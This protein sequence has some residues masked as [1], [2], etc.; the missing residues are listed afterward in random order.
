MEKELTVQ[1]MPSA[2]LHVLDNILQEYKAKVIQIFLQLDPP[3]IRLLVEN[4]ECIND[5]IQELSLS[6]HVFAVSPSLKVTDEYNEG[7]VT[8]DPYISVQRALADIKAFDAWQI[9]KGSRDVA[10]AVIDKGVQWKNPDLLPN[11]IPTRYTTVIHDWEYRGG[12]PS[13]WWVYDGITDDSYIHVDLWAG[14]VQHGTQM[15]GII[16]AQDN[17]ATGTTGVAPDCYIASPSYHGSMDYFAS[18]MILI[19]DNPQLN[20]KVFAISFGYNQNYY[21]QNISNPV[22]NFVIS[23]I[24]YA[25]DRGILCVFA[26]G[27]YGTVQP[28]DHKVAFP[29]C[30]TR[31][32]SDGK[33]RAMIGVAASSHRYPSELVTYTSIGQGVDI[34]APGQ[35]TTTMLVG[36]GAGITV[37][38]KN[39]GTADGTSFASPFVAGVAALVYSVNPN[40]T[41]WQVRDILMSTSNKTTLNPN[42]PTVPG[43]PKSIPDNVYPSDWYLH[44]GNTQIEADYAYTCNKGIVDAHA[45]T[46]AAWETRP[47]PVVRP[48]VPNSNIDAYADSFVLSFEEAPPNDNFRSFNLVTSSILAG[49]VAEDDITFITGVEAGDLIVY[50]DS[51]SVTGDPCSS[52][53]IYTQGNSIGIID[54]NYATCTTN[55]TNGIII[56]NSEILIAGL[57]D[58]SALTTEGTLAGV[59]LGNHYILSSMVTKGEIAGGLSCM[60]ASSTIAV[61]IASLTGDINSD[62]NNVSTP[63]INIG[64]LVPV[65]DGAGS[66]RSPSR[67]VNIIDSSGRRI[68]IITYVNG[69]WQ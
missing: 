4:S 56:Y 37:G 51:S 58:S 30:I 35:H 45:A 38:D 33:E 16:A 26:A 29:P 34:C 20:I 7:D 57:C 15:A 41:A 52:I 13:N 42:L 9:T 22:W 8:N 23:A 21:Q 43:P 60:D 67:G 19:A 62:D 65:L 6:E 54:S 1:L 27:N 36:S 64:R 49:S 46:L 28:T 24:D 2:D 47:E 63:F 32:R 48:P 44:I 18:L 50:T 14:E 12:I 11:R 66:I 31:T 5:L 25:N 3:F 68:Y 61:G 53:S 69:A 59:P 39:F 40:L 17:N 10:V 55:V